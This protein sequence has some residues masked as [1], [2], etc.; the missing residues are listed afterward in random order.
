MRYTNQE[1]FDRVY[2][3][4]IINE[5]PY[6][7]DDKGSCM[8]RGI[9][10]RKCAGGLFIKDE[11]YDVEYEGNGVHKLPWGRW[12]IEFSEFRLLEELQA[13]HDQ[14]RSRPT[15]AKIL[16]TVADRFGLTVPT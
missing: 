11:D 10:G 13:A 12:G 6:S 14:L 9:E 8:Y 15:F 2:T 4:F 16:A 7:V 1:V 5:E 3:H